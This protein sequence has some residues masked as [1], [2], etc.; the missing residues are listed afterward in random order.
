MR[1]GEQYTLIVGGDQHSISIEPCE[2]DGYHVFLNGSCVGSVFRHRNHNFH[3][4]HL[5]T[6]RIFSGRTRNKAVT[7]MVYSIQ[8]ST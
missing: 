7:A 4:R 8:K 1:I 6:G 3:C 5:D 2:D